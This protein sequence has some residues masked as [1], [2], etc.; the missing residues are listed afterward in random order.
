MTK[1]IYDLVPRETRFITGSFA[2]HADGAFL[3]GAG[4]DTRGENRNVST[5]KSFWRNKTP[6]PYVS[7]QA[8]RRWLR[9][10]LVEETGWEPS[11]IE[12]VM[13][14]DKGSSSKIAGKLD[15]L[16][17][18]EDDIFGYMFT[19]AKDKKESEVERRLPEVQLV[20]SSPFKTSILRGLPNLSKISTDEGFVH[21]KEGTPLPYSTE[22]Y[23]AELG[24]TF[25]LELYRLGVFENIGNS[26]D[27]IDPHLVKN[28]DLLEEHDHPTI[29]KAKVYVRKNVVDY[30]NNLAKELLNALAFLRGGSKL[31]QFGVDVAPK[32]L[33]L[34][35]MK[36]GGMIFDNLLINSGGSPALNLAALEEIVADYREK[37]TTKI[38]L[39]I[40]EGYLSNQEEIR[41]I[42][43]LG[44]IE[45][46]H[47]SPSSV[48]KKFADELV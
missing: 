23:S 3:N 35:G 37:I 10:T 26:K 44:G 12:P 28:T 8:W 40:R 5:V 32:F 17:F 42:T 41:Q 39:G 25:A 29:N 18:P 9:N 7:A 16:N 27:E 4:L 24:A 14:S 15:P 13:T 19:A 47:G 22:F 48:A 38:Y 20:R 11:I 2:V 6:V 36:V 31:A 33:I 45:V 34:A 1:T 30:Q 43:E 21:L 46:V